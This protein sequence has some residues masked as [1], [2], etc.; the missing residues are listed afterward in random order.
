MFYSINHFQTAN[1]YEHYDSITHV[2]IALLEYF[3]NIL[4]HSYLHLVQKLFFFGTTCQVMFVVYSNLYNLFVAKELFDG[5]SHCVLIF[6]RYI[7][8]QTKLKVVD[9]TD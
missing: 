4:K 9:N 3:L 7:T 2:A 5:Q 6:G 8:T 1:Y